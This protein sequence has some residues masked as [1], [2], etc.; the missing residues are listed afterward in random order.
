[1]TDLPAN[2]AR[3]VQADGDCVIWLGAR[4]NR[5]YGS[6]GVGGKRTALVHR[7][8]Y[9]ATVAPIPADMTI[10]HLCRNKLCVNVEHLE[11]VTR[12][13]NSKR[14]AR[15]RYPAD[16]T[17]VGNGFSEIFEKFFGQYVNRA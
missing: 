15:H 9:E 10:D 3:H 1:M 11:V 13:E 4:N 17:P 16:T 5:G 7:H 2:V 8:V 14:A 12:S 6:V